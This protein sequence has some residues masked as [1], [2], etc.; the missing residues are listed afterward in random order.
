MPQTPAS[1]KNALG[2]PHKGWGQPGH[3]EWSRLEAAA[4]L[5]HEA[6]SRPPEDGSLWRNPRLTDCS[7]ETIPTLEGLW[8]EKPFETLGPA[9]TVLS[10][11]DDWGGVRH[12]NSGLG[13]HLRPPVDSL[14]ASL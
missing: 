5:S 2:S 10:V 11:G 14:V 12:W 3:R 7:A 4:A 1:G 9:W 13:N 8:A 6:W